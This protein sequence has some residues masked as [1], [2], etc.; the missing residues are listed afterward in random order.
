[1][2]PLALLILAHAFFFFAR[3]DEDGRQPL[4][5]NH[6]LTPPTPRQSKVQIDRTAKYALQAILIPSF[7]TCSKITL[8]CQRGVR[9]ALGA[10]FEP[11]FIRSFQTSFL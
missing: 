6:F 3:P 10:F 1:M 4:P 5:W 11:S 7:K 2:V 8:A 9:L